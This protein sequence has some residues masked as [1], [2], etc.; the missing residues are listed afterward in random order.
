MNVTVKTRDE[1]VKEI[2]EIVEGILQDQVKGFIEGNI[3]ALNMFSNWRALKHW[4]D[5]ELVNRW[6]D[7]CSEMFFDQ[8][9]EV[10]EVLMDITSMD[11]NGAMVKVE[12]VWMASKEDVRLYK[13]GID[14]DVAANTR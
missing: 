3:E 14:K 7:L 13:D 12:K 2:S 5:G 6:C 11:V 4:K 1:V 9:P 8:H 10:D